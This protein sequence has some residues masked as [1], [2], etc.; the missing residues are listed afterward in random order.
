MFTFIG[1]QVRRYLL[2]LV[3]II[4]ENFPKHLKQP[5]TIIAGVLGQSSSNIVPP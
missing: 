3:R 4:Q 5:R 2:A 1:S